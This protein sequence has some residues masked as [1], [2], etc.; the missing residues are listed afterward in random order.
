MGAASAPLRILA[1]S[2][3][4]S[5]EVCTFARLV[6][7]MQAL[8]DAGK[9]EY[10]F[11]TLFLRSIPGLRRLLR[12]LRN[13]DVIWILRPHHYV[14]LPIIAEAR[15]LGKPVLVDIDD[16]LLE[17]PADLGDAA[18]FMNRP[19]QETI[20]LAL[21]S[22]TAITVSTG[23]IAER[24]AA[25]GLRAH[26]VPNSVDC[27]RFTRQPRDDGA[28]TIGFCGSPSHYLDVPLIT[29]GLRSLLR[30][31]PERVRVVSMGCPLPELRD[32]PGYTHHEPVAPAEYPRALSDLRLDIGLA[33]LHD[34][35]FNDAK[36]DIKCLE[37]SATGAATIAS[38]V[39]PY[40]ASVRGDCGV[41]VEANTPE[42]WSG[43]LRRLVKDP[44][45]R[46]RLADNAY[47]WVRRERA[48]ASAT[49]MDV[50][51]A[52]FQ[53]YAIGSMADRTTPMSC[54]DRDCFRRAT[55]NIVLRQL[56]GDIPRIYSGLAQEV[57]ARLRG[58]M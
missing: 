36:S 4:D 1:L 31:Y 51:L 13:W 58:A 29:P 44:P 23:V 6:T 20:R 22:A 19:C 40:R 37:Y 7:P 34:T 52:V 53:G 17:L 57:L 33:P 9:I 3:N 46:R 41:L 48:S 2:H 25:L 54:V 56:P 26:V 38:P 49:M 5:T 15:R 28:L 32:L 21:R 50:W 10:K 39:P 12:D 14:I 18:Y 35:F 30:E 47:E 45:S 27:A 16:W 11:V 42:A 8:Q 55:A 24:C 43:A